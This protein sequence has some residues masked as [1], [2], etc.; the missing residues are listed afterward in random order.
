MNNYK[1]LLPLAMFYMTIKVTTVLMIY[2]IVTIHGI[3]ASAATLIIPLWFLTGDIIAEVYG[4]KIAKQLIWIAIVCQFVYAFI[5]AA[6]AYIPSPHD[7]LQNHEAYK[8]ILSGLPRVAF[9]SFLAIAVGGIFNAYAINK[10]KVLLRGKYFGLRSLGASSIGELI[11]TLCAYLIEFIGKTSSGN[12]MQ[13]IMVSY[14]IKLTINPILIIPIAI[15]T[16]KIKHSEGIIEYSDMS[17]NN[18]LK[19]FVQQNISTSKVTELYTGVDSKSYFKDVII[20]TP[21]V[22]P[23]GSYSNGVKVTQLQFRESQPNAKFDWHTAPQKQYVIYLEGEV[24]VQASNGETRVFKPGDILLANDL[25]GKGH[26]TTTLTN[27]RSIVIT[28]S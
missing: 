19:S 1:W 3:S 27:G 17:T 14:L 11:F 22:H 28:T 16:R 18:I 21:V 2:K 9:A 26:I 4:Y 12:I 15:L 7:V 24:Q 10:W 5:C 6:F 20:E 25:T 13:L 8:E 23:L